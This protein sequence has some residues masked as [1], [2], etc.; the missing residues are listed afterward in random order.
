M[1]MLILCC[2]VLAST[3]FPVDVEA[4]TEPGPKFDD[5]M[6]RCS[7]PKS[8]PIKEISAYF[9]VIWCA[10]GE[11]DAE[12]FGF[13][14]HYDIDEKGEIVMKAWGARIVNGKDFFDDAFIALRFK[15]GAW[16]V[17][18]QGSG[19]NFALKTTSLKKIVIT[20]SVVTEEGET[21][22]RVFTIEGHELARLME[23]S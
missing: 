11:G 2:L 5:G 14:L 19:F 15:D 4:V 20:L 6:W 16:V 12:E 8:T 10:R 17:N 1:R 3:L 22:V 7:E 23:R 21:V 9:S 18:K 13:L